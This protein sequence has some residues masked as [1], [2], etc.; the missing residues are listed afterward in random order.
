MQK[1]RDFYEMWRAFSITPM[2][3]RDALI[4]LFPSLAVVELGVHL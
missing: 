2:T 1:K 4:S 3:G